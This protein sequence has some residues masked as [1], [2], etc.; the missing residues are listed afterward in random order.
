MSQPG[1]GLSLT[2][3]AERERRQR[4]AARAAVAAT[5]AP[6][7]VSGAGR[8][9][10]ASSAP[11]NSAPPRAAIAPAAAA[12]AL[13]RL[14]V[15][16][17]AARSYSAGEASSYTDDASLVGRLYIDDPVWGRWVSGRGGES[18]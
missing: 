10:A 11:A 3:Q 5:A 14:E 12:D 1:P 15:N 2:A 7:Q 6:G 13:T 17:A 16:R 9:S 8:S 18:R 4:E